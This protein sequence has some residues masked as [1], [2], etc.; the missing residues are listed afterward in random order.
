MPADT[1]DPSDERELE[2]LIQVLR[3]AAAVTNPRG[4][5]LHSPA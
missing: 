4:P 5:A 2:R 1:Q 3:A